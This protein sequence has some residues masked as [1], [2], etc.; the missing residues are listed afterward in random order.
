MDMLIVSSRWKLRQQIVALREER[1]RLKDQ[2]EA[3]EAVAEEII[4][5]CAWAEGLAFSFP[6]WVK[7]T[8]LPMA[9]AALEMKTKK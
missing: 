3:L 4:D 2:I 1:G 7:A 5:T 9:Q 8:L 6:D